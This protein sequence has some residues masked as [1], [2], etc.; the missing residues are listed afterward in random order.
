MTDSLMLDWNAAMQD[1]LTTGRAYSPGAIGGATIERMLAIDLEWRD[2][3]ERLPSGVYQQYA[4]DG[5]EPSADPALNELCMTI[6]SALR[7]AA[8][9]V[10]GLSGFAV[11][12]ASFH[13]YRPG[14]RGL[15]RH[16]DRDFYHYLVIG[17][18][19]AG[20]G[21]LLL[22]DDDGPESRP[23][24]I[25]HTEPGD[26]YLFRAPGLQSGTADVRPAHATG[27]TVAGR[28]SLTLRYNSHGFGGG[29][30]ASA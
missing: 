28:T 10:A 30:S 25:W 3:D 27:L 15:G 9:L 18:T 2:L 29:W 20:D 5:M 21:E 12:E 13:R 24:E 14:D 1:V 22:F 23:T 26:L 17:I 11:N 8:P 19:L 16:R 7:R 6:G 4:Y